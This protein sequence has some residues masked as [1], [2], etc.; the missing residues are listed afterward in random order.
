MHRLEGVGLSA[1]ALLG[2]D[3]ENWLVGGPR[4]AGSGELCRSGRR[5]E[6]GGPT[7]GA[8]GGGRGPARRGTV[9]GP[10]RGAHR[11][12]ERA[13]AYLSGESREV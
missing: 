13:G 2:G 1:L 3:R 7:A 11:E 4:A 5:Q 9:E 8:S 10:G 12:V 6:V